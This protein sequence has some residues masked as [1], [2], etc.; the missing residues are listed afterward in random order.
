MR[1]MAFM[2]TL[3]AFIATSCNSPVIERVRDRDDSPAPSATTVTEAGRSV[4][5]LPEQTPSSQ[6]QASNTSIN[7]QP[8]SPENLAW[9]E[10]TYGLQIGS[11]DF[12]YDPISGGWGYWGGPTVGFSDHIWNLAT[13]RATLLA[14]EPGYF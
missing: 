8:L 10:M 3:C 13:P 14:E 4:P 12:W 1:A 2:L 11:G 7:G 5:S 6:R 9:I